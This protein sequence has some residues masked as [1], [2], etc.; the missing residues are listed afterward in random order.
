MKT[1]DLIL[2]IFG[3]LATPILSFIIGILSSKIKKIKTAS[4]E[5]EKKRELEWNAI[6]ETCKETL[7]STL[8]EDYEFY[9]AQGWC[10]VEDKDEVNNVYTLYHKGLHGNGRGTRYYSGIISLPEHN[11]N[12]EEHN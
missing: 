8:K 5:N 4:E 6:K 7:R 2:Q 1:S 3:M 12:E 11:P 10:S 9:T